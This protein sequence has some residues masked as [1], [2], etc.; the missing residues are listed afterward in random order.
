M[1]QINNTSKK[2]ARNAKSTVDNLV[3]RDGIPEQLKYVHQVFT[4][5]ASSYLILSMTSGGG[6]IPVDKISSIFQSTYGRGVQVRDLVFITIICP[7]MLMLEYR[8]E[9]DMMASNVSDSHDLYSPTTSSQQQAQSS[10]SQQVLAVRFIDSG[11]SKKK[12]QE[13]LASHSEDLRVHKV[14]IESQVESAVTQN[15]D[16]KPRKRAGKRITVSGKKAQVLLQRRIQTFTQAVN[17]F[18]SDN[19]QSLPQDLELLID[20]YYPQQPLV[21]LESQHVID[22]TQQ[23]S[24]DGDGLELALGALTC[25]R[26]FDD[27]QSIQTFSV[28]A[29]APSFMRDEQIALHQNV[30]QAIKSLYSLQVGQ[31][32]SHQ[33]EALRA[34]ICDGKS[35]VVSTSTSS[36][37]SLIYNLPIVND[38][39]KLKDLQQQQQLDQSDDKSQIFTAL[40]MFPTKALAQDQ[41]QKVRLLLDACGLDHIRVSTYDGDTPMELRE[42]IRSQSHII[43][44]NPDMLHVSILPQH[45]GGWKQFLSRLKYVIV[46]ELHTLTGYFG[47]HVAFIMRRLQRVLAFYQSPDSLSRL[48]FIAC[49]ATISNPLDHTCQ[50]L[51]LSQERCI[52]IT[53][54]G[55]PHAAKSI[56][57]IKQNEHSIF[58]KAS[59]LIV[60]LCKFGLRT[61]A[62]CK[63]RRM[64][65]YILREVQSIIDRDPSLHQLRGKIKTYRGGYQPELRRQIESELFSGEL[66]CVV[67]TTAL[68]LGIDVGDLDVTVHCGFPYTLS[69][70]WQQAGR[71]GRS[72]SASAAILLCDKDPIDYYYAARPEKL[73][74]RQYEDATLSMQS[75]IYDQQLQCAA[76]EYP[77]NLNQDVQ[78]FDNQLESICRKALVS[79][80]NNQY[81]PNLQYLPSPAALI[82]IRCPQE[83]SF[84]VVDITPGNGDQV[85]EELEVSRA[86][87]SLYEGAVYMHQGQTYIVQ[88]ADFHSLT[89][90]VLLQNVNYITRQR[91]FTDV[92]SQKAQLT[93]ALSNGNIASYGD[94]SVQKTIFGYFKY[95]PK[96][97]KVLENVEVYWE[98]VVKQCY[99]I[100]MQLAPGAVSEIE[101]TQ[102]LSLLGGIHGLAHLIC[103]QISILIMCNITDLG[104]E[105]PSQY[106]TRSRPNLIIIY[107]K[108]QS[109]FAFHAFQMI[110][111]IL[112]Q[113]VEVLDSCKCEDGCPQCIHSGYCTEFNEV[114][115]KK[116][117]QILLHSMTRKCSQQ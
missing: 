26:S 57:V 61:I 114:T 95:D 14:F 83:D 110:Q 106:Q 63:Y 19:N 93:Q 21:D 107:D 97:K 28:P 92:N 111:K 98:P 45:N 50:L 29:K 31:L 102:S 54:D 78:Y 79:V 89:A 62:F 13:Q 70:F 77:I 69:G 117:A 99:G 49:S 105:H 18:W 24:V 7:Q 39:L 65:E 85:L 100:W 109:G 36:G 12:Q 17:Q 40:Y 42:G 91:D 20:A 33:V 115:D 113:C 46:D 88:Y 11:D 51:N 15:H 41:M 104:C 56:L 60:H 27:D 1:S 81:L 3:L 90:G 80:G 52:S 47:S 116:A 32:Y 43:I 37:K 64:C 75:P 108:T 6:F 48:R 34:V 58:D 4:Q 59:H 25:L 76:A 30:V 5:L 87:S 22:S 71:A 96:K 103:S 23:F 68:E 9:S 53:Q 35:V 16:G 74:D 8:S 10:G 2:R 38:Y 66:L 82:S 55:S 67:A 112:L 86:L 101:G 94:V 72:R 73:M 44:T 84:S